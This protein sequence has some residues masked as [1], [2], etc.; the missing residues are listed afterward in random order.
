MRPFQNEL[1]K[2]EDGAVL[3]LLGH[4]GSDI[5]AHLRR[6]AFLVDKKSKKSIDLYERVGNGGGENLKSSFKN[7]PATSVDYSPVEKT[8]F[9]WPEE[10]TGPTREEQLNQIKGEIGNKLA[11][12]RIVKTVDLPEYENSMVADA[13]R[14]VAQQHDYLKFVES[15]SPYRVKKKR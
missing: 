9:H 12:N 4:T 13:L 2:G 11:D 14:D 3:F 8:V 5:H 15:K 1:A 7:V 6:N 10:D